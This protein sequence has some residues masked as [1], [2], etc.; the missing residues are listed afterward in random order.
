MLLLQSRQ[1]EVDFDKE[2][3][4][5]KSC[6]YEPHQ[7]KNLL[8]LVDLCEQ[9]KF[10]EAYEFACEWGHDRDPVIECREAEFIGIAIV[11]LLRA[12][13]SGWKFEVANGTG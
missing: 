8:K 3:E 2:R 12:Y 7:Q 10:K 5:I 13:V 9:L 4:R 1:I 6:E 11:E